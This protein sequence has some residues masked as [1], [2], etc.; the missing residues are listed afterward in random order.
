VTNVPNGASARTVVVNWGDGTGSQNLG[1]ISGNALVSHVYERSGSYPITATMTDTAG[2]V[3]SV[4][5]SVTV[6]PIASPT[7]VITPSVPSS[8]TGLG[9]SCTVT[10]QIQVTPPS[11]VGVQN[12]TVAFGDGNS[13]GLGGLSGS[14]SIQHTYSGTTHGPVTVTVTVLDTLERT[15]QGFT[16]INLP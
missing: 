15:T 4:S 1:A 3:T 10:F 13:Q 5:S 6:V 12:A 7:I 14:V 8:C 9:P 2:N 11:G 16:T